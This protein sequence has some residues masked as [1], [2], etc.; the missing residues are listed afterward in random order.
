MVKCANTETKKSKGLFKNK[1]VASIM[2]FGLM[3]FAGVTLTACGDK[4]V[5]VENVSALVSNYATSTNKFLDNEVFEDTIKFS[6]T[7]YD[8]NN[9]L[10]ATYDLGDGTKTSYFQL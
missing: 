4:K 6:T 1:I 3:L 7:T 2:A 8:E 5:N 9:L 10:D